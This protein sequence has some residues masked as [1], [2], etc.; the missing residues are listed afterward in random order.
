LSKEAG[1]RVA[2]SKLMMKQ[3]IVHS[4]KRVFDGFLKMDEAEVSYERLNGSMGKPVRRLCVERGDSVALIVYR[5]DTQAIILVR[6]FK[7]P[8]FEKGPGWLIEAMAGSIDPGETPEAAAKRETLEEIGYAVENLEFIARFYVTP[9]GSSERIF[10]YYAE[11]GS[12][13]KIAAGGGVASEG[14]DIEL[15]EFPMADLD[16]LLREVED[17]KTLV[18]LYWLQKRN[19][20]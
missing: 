6:Q 15:I 8:T 10:L 1:P 5:R 18:G 3:A 14:E 11:V 19:Q 9:G 13:D 7:Y 17:A 20:T 12:A 16:R 4:K 2:I